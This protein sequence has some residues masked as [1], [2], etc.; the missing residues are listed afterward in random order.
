MATITKTAFVADL[1]ETHNMNRQTAQEAVDAI[2][3]TLTQTLI[4]GLGSNCQDWA[5]SP[6]RNG[7]DT[8]ES[9][10][11]P[12]KRTIQFKVARISNDKSQS[13]HDTTCRMA[14]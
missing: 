13:Q 3:L 2:V 14:L 8:G 6:S 10:N 11:I 1:A 7:L 4:D 9:L 5:A 12:A